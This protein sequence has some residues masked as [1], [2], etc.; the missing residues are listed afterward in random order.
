MNIWGL[1]AFPIWRD[2]II[3]TENTAYANFDAAKFSL[4]ANLGPGDSLELLMEGRAAKRPGDAFISVRVNDIVAGYLKYP[5]KGF[6]EYGDPW[7]PK[8]ENVIIDGKTYPELPQ[9]YGYARGANYGPGVVSGGA[10]WVGKELPSPVLAFRLVWHDPA[11]VEVDAAVNFVAYNDWSFDRSRDYDADQRVVSCPVSLVVDTRQWIPFTIRRLGCVKISQIV[12]DNSITSAW[13]V[14]PFY[15]FAGE[16][17]NEPGIFL[18]RA[19]DLSDFAPQLQGENARRY[20]IESYPGADD[21]VTPQYFPEDF[22]NYFRQARML[23]APAIMVRNTCAKYCVYYVNAYGGWD[24]YLLR[25]RAVVSDSIAKSEYT[26]GS[27]TDLVGGA[28]RRG[29]DI[30]SLNVIKHLEAHTEWLTD[31]EAGRMHHLTESA[32]IYIH[33]LETDEIFPAIFTGSEHV[34]KTYRN[35]G[36]RLVSYKLDFDFATSHQRA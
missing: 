35:Q 31:E 15:Q 13:S 12:S 27:T 11:G 6:P 20:V 29:R 5:E 23:S 9:Y 34:Y 28:E 7:T 36:G 26:K 1:P 30:I 10:M 25:G 21:S 3:T 18:L 32:N 17:Q 19:G 2:V 24:W 14:V 8:R 22:G 4:Y 16:T 33:D